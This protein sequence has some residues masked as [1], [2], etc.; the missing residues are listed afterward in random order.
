MTAKSGRRVKR[1]SARSRLRSS[2]HVTASG[3]NVFA[4]LGFSPR[5]AENLKIRSLLMSELRDPIAGLTQ[6]SAAQLLSVSP[7]RGWAV[8][9][10]SL[11]RPDT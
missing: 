4:D 1:S 5:E 9:P 8:A 10:P 11:G 6:V 2:T 7:P 3:G